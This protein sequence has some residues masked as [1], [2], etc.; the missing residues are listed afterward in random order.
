MKT[1]RVVIGLLALVVGL[2]NLLRGDWLGFVLDSAIG[3]SLLLDPR[4]PGAAKWR[5]GLMVVIGVC[6]LLRLLS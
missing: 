3:W 5:V 1:L 6:V 4:K 2:L